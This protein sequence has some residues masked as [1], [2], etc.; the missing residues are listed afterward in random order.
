M[1]TVG[2]GVASEGN[3]TGVARP[4]SF[5]SYTRGRRFIDV[6]N[7]GFST[8]S[9]TVSAS[10][11]W[12]L[13][14]ATSGAIADQ[15]RLWV[16]IDW[17]AAPLGPSSPQVSITAASQTITVPL[18]VT[19]DGA[20]AR[21]TARG[22]VEAHGY[23]SIEAEHFDRQIRRGGAAWQRIPGLGRSGSVVITTPFNASPI[24]GDVRD[25]APELQ[26]TVRFTGTG[27]YPV[28]VF[29]L[30][31]LDERGARRLAIGLDSGAA[32]VLTGQAIA[33]GTAW[34]RNV[35]EGIEKLT[36]MITVDRPGEHV[37]K[38]W[39]VDAAV[40]VD[41]IVIDTGGLPATYLAPPESFNPHE[42]DR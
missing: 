12:V 35:V 3:E 26:Y 39:M 22:F 6:F 11:P 30:P 8:L 7:T 14:S 25:Q 41:Q 38:L 24:G 13:V 40:A 17:A 34:S 28:T 2:L 16:S 15:V 21:R 36:A 5:S 23:V 37:L 27:S 20:R 9:W 18:E 1:D 31:S 33:S 10:D 32:T 4:L 19:N 42:R 29:R